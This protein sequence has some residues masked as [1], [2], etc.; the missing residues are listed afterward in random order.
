L[1]ADMIR[2]R[3]DCDLKK[4]DEPRITDDEWQFAL[5]RDWMARQEFSPTED[6]EERL[7][8]SA[9][10][11]VQHVLEWRSRPH[12]EI[13][14]DPL[15]PP[16][17]WAAEAAARLRRYERLRAAVLAMLELMSD[18]KPHYL[19]IS[20]VPGFL[21]AIHAGERQEGD[22]LVLHVP[23][24]LVP[25]DNEDEDYL[26][27]GEEL[28]VWRGSS[29]GQ[30]RDGQFLREP[31]ADERSREQRLAR[32]AEVS[33]HIA[34]RTGCRPVEVVAYLL[35]DYPLRPKWVQISFSPE[36]DGYLII[37]RDPRVLPQH[38]AQAYRHRREVL[39]LRTR[40]VQTGPLAVVWH[41]DAAKKRIDFSWLRAY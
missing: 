19:K 33:L 26:L 32:L 14:A 6:A 30:L 4:C 27:L 36:H 41:V 10:E 35:C 5:G 37:V 9:D 16:S 29:R 15:V 22:W 2:D 11:V 17:W 23:T 34:E 18:D 3:A 21:A 38:V 13:S 39:G 24:E 31:T 1:Y 12:R 8:E 40:A 25:L 7:G 28:L 20:E